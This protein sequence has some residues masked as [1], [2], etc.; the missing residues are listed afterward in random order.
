MNFKKS[1]RVSGITVV[2]DL[3]KGFE[4]SFCEFVLINSCVVGVNSPTVIVVVSIKSF[5]SEALS[6]S[7]KIGSKV[8]ISGNNV[9]ESFVVIRLLLVEVSCTSVVGIGNVTLS[10][11]E[12][13]MLHTR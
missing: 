10:K 12:N 2:V 9:G 11:L 6:V 4:F 7:G 1:G 3:V 13:K 5:P 8:E